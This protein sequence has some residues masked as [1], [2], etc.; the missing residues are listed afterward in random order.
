[1]VA[2]VG[3]AVFRVSRSGRSEPEDIEAVRK[4]LDQYF[5]AASTTVDLLSREW[6]A[7]SPSERDRLRHNAEEHA[8]DNA[9]PK[10][11]QVS[12]AFDRLLDTAAALAKDMRDEG[13]KAIQSTSILLVGGSFFIALLNL[14]LT[15]SRALGRDTGQS[16][17]SEPDPKSFR[18]DHT[19]QRPPPSS[20]VLSIRP[21]QLFRRTAVSSSCCSPNESGFQVPAGRPA[22]VI[23]M[24]L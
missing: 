11:I 20:E 22:R 3:A 16:S 1:S 21:L 7:A 4:S 13:T 18:P 24:I 2:R 19:S 10:M 17:E 9:G 6:N 5:S 8:A 12:L 14:F 23:C 15:K